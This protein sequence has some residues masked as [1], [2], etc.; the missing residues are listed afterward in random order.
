MTQG[1]QR[2]LTAA[3]LIWMLAVLLS[4]V[5]GLIREMVIARVAGANG[6]TDV[7]FSAFQIPDFLN[8]LV[9]GGALSITFIP[10]FLGFIVQKEE[11]EGWSV[12]STVF[13]LMLATL[14]VLMV[15]GWILAP[16]ICHWAQPGFDAEQQRLLVRYTRILLPAQLF[17]VAGGLFGAVQMAQ[18]RHAF[19]ASAAIVYNVGIILGGLILAPTLGMEGF[20][21]GAL[22]GA[23]LGHG[24]LQAVGAHRT[25]MRLLP[26]VD[27]KSSA[28]HR[29]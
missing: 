20:C 3:T 16:L 13:H 28:V 24:V 27:L 14:S 25:G 17:F 15:L 7:Y 19:Y 26:R 10:I 4:R 6:M 1:T 8:Y 18:G 29:W 9:A 2:Q 21:W 5:V 22:A 23:F 12:F 11:T